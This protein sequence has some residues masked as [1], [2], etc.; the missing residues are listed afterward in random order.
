MGRLEQK[1]I[2][3]TGASSGIGREA[4]PRF[5]AEGARLALLGR[6][7]KHLAEAV[8]AARAA[9]GEARA[10]TADVSDRASITR[11]IDDAAGWLGGIDVLVLN[12]AEASYGPFRDTPAEDFDHTVATVFGGGVDTVRAGLPYLTE[13]SGLVLANLSV[14]SRMPVPMFSSYVASKHALRGFLGSLRIE[15]QRED[16][17]VRVSIVHPGHVDT[18]FWGRVASATGHL[19][20]L[21]PLAYSA[22]R[23]AGALVDAAVDEPREHT[24]GALAKL[25]LV[26]AAVA[27]PLV[28]VGGRLLGR[29]LESGG[30]PAA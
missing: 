7:K 8:D 12:A 11:G 1:R 5:A 28:D 25:Q 22:D 16:S 21:P 6:D 27:M 9:G 20:R 19:P 18:P 23:I 2:V 15:L 30:E 17:D 13:S 26:T 29:W 10:F 4:V 3:L 24:V 14:L